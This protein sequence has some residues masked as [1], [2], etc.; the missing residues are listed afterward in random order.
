MIICLKLN[1][2]KVLILNEFYF[3]GCMVTIEG[4]PGHGS[5]FLKNTAGEKLTKILQKFYEFRDS[6][7]EKLKTNPN[8][9]IGDVT[10]INLTILQVYI[11]NF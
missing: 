11:F 10:T 4:Q 7:E 8:L 6:E 5:Q 1:G 9:R 3:I 2:L